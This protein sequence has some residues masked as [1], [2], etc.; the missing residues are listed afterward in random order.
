[1]RTTL[2]FWNNLKTK[3]KSND[4]KVMRWALLLYFIPSINSISTK[5]NYGRLISRY[6]GERT[7]AERGQLQ[8]NVK[9][10]SGQLRLPIALAT[11]GCYYGKMGKLFFNLGLASG[12]ERPRTCVPS[13]NSCQLQIKKAC[14]F[15]LPAATLKPFWRQIS[16][17][18]NWTSI[19]K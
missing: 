13:G 2:D 18:I 6:L 14:R 10:M 7:K 17:Q 9:R 11:G 1:M 3:P 4:I 8:N 19:W 5:T 16:N 12:K 15:H